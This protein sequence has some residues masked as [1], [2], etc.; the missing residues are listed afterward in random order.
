MEGCSLI[1]NTVLFAIIQFLV[2]IIQAITGFAG[3]PL[4]MPP[5]IA[6]VG[7]QDA[8]AAVTFLLWLSSL[9]VSIRSIKDINFKQLLIMILG[10]LPGVVLGLWLF[11]NSPLNI[12]MLIYGIVVILIGL[13][14]LLIK[15]KGELPK[16]LRYAAILLAGLMQG[17][18]TSGGPFLAIY[19]TAAIKDKR[20]FRATV[21]SVW[22]LLNIYMVVSMFRKNMYTPVT[23]KLIAVSV[24]PL[25]VAIAIGNI[26]NKKMKQEFFLKFV[27]C[28]LI[29]SGSLLI[30]NYFA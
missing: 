3:G 27:Y 15:D 8:K 23:G 6:I 28:L 10:M 14:K 7:A 16:W 25:F 11:S 29:V 17:M 26:L 2:N 20:E 13:K 18:F 12:L 4:A 19:S 24:I 9:T 30:Y 22:S 5:S 21:S 1:L